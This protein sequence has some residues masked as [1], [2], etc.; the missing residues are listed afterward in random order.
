MHNKNIEYIK[1]NCVSTVTRKKKKKGPP[2][3]YK[4]CSLFLPFLL[5]RNWTLSKGGWRRIEEENEARSDTVY[6]LVLYFVL[7][8]AV[9]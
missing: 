2:P 9:Q 7:N 3:Y 4:L 5:L 6:V 8:S 1:G